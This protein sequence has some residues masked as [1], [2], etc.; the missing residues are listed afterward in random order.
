MFGIGKPTRPKAVAFDII[1]T[2]FPLEPLRPRVTALGLPPAALEGWFAAGLRDAFALALT[3][4][5]EP[6]TK[7]LESA[8]DGTLAEQGLSAPHHDKKAL[9][10]ALQDLV[11]RAGAAEALSMLA[12]AGITVLALTNGSRASTQKLLDRAG[13]AAP[14]RHIVSVDDVKRSKPAADVYVHAAQV[15]GVDPADL[16]LIAAHSWDIQGGHAAGLTTAYLSA[17]RPFPAALHAPDVEA[18]TLPECAA[19]LL[20]L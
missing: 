16:A 6:F 3:G 19:K 14:P 12:D 15:A 2:T 18:D 7:V 8:L 4:S 1:G 10:E 9:V 13:F 17:E 20:A 5:F 11:P